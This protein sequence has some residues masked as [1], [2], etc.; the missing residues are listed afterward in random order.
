M[1]HHT[2][3]TLYQSKSPIN[4]SVLWYSLNYPNDEIGGKVSPQ[5]K[6]KGDVYL[7]MGSWISGKALVRDV[8]IPYN[9]GIISLSIHLDQNISRIGDYELVR[10]HRIARGVYVSGLIRP[11]EH[12]HLNRRLI[13]GYDLSIYGRCH[14]SNKTYKQIQRNK[15]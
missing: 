1:L 10:D 12:E 15:R 6:I 11:G 2:V 8:K 3:Q 14:T 4:G 5:V 9:M 7:P 13:V